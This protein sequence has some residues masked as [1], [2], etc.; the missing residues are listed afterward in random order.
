MGNRGEHGHEQ[1]LADVSSKC[2]GLWS[3]CSFMRG[4]LMGFNVALP[5][6]SDGMMMS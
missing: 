4:V 3:A 2:F 6:L 5:D 1:P